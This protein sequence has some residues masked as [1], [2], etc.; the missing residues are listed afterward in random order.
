[1]LPEELFCRTHIH[2]TDMT[3]LSP[4]AL[5]NGAVAFV[6]EKQPDHG[7]EYPLP[8]G[9]PV[10]I[11]DSTLQQLGKLSAAFCDK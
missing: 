2:T 7:E 3:L 11:V 5:E 4:Q 1:M 9:F 10:L 6:A 8:E